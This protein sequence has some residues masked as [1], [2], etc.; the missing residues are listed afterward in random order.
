MA[1]NLARHIKWHCVCAVCKSVFNNNKTAWCRASCKY[2]MQF[3][4][5][6]KAL[7]TKAPSHNT[8]KSGSI[9]KFVN[10][11]IYLSFVHFYHTQKK[12][13]LCTYLKCTLYPSCSINVRI[14]IEICFFGSVFLLSRICGMWS[15][16]IFQFSLRCT[17]CSSSIQTSKLWRK[18]NL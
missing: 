14:T 6:S 9:P 7:L 18:P 13:N 1:H 3:K 8:H 17:S 11:W 2:K 4:K 5:K 15:D 16:R 10:S 12:V